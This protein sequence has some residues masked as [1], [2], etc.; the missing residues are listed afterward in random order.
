[1]N[2]LNEKIAM[3]EDFKMWMS[4]LHGYFFADEARKAANR[5][6]EYCPE[7]QAGQEIQEEW[8]NYGHRIEMQNAIIAK[9]ASWLA[10]PAKVA[11]RKMK[12]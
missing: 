8:S 4:T 7:Y 3:V 2:T 6:E 10:G 5:G 1:M 9:M 12:R 11:L